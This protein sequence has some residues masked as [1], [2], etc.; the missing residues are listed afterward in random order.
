[1]NGSWVKSAQTM[2]LLLINNSKPIHICL[3]RNPLPDLPVNKQ[4]EP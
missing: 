4:A 3:N 1:M 2:N